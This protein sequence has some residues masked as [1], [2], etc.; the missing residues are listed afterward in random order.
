MDWK[1]E[2]DP[3]AEKEIDKLDRQIAK[4]L[5]TFLYKRL[6]QLENPRDIGEPLKGS[7]LGEFWK[8]RVGDYRIVVFI[9][10]D[11]LRILV[12]KVGHRKEVYKKN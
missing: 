10:D 2:F 11:V 3:N 8:Y 9:E 12:V 4:R 5:L 1:I 7:Q 6:S